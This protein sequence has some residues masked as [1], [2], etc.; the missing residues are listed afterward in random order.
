MCLGRCVG[1][2][3]RPCRFM[4]SRK[5]LEWPICKAAQAWWAATSW[6]TPPRFLSPSVAKATL[7]V[8]KSNVALAKRGA[9]GSQVALLTRF[10]H[11]SKGRAHAVTRGK[12]KQTNAQVCSWCEAPGGTFQT[13]RRKSLLQGRSHLKENQT[14]QQKTRANA[15]RAFAHN[16]LR[17]LP[18]PGFL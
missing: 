7:T 18:A 16:G 14:K 4:P 12:Q 2:A 9:R 17:T 13:H 5:C 6:T 10:G 15:S 11:F 3:S 8:T 1:G